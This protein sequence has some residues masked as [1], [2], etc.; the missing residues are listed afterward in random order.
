MKK[1]REAL[2]GKDPTSQGGTDG[3]APKLLTPDEIK[4]LV[5]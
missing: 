2:Y 3:V 5:Q 1:V 4:A